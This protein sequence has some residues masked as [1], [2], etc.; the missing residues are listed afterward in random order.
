M[1]FRK[2]YDP[3][4]LKLAQVIMLLKLGKPTEDITSY[5]PISLLLSLSKLLEKLL[6]ERLKP[7]IEANNV[8][9]EH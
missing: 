1:H 3:A 8:M 5:R 2:E 6:L 7:I 9:P 4:Q